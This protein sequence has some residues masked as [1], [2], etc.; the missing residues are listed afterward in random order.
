MKLISEGRI[1]IRIT[2]H[3]YRYMILTNG[4]RICSAMTSPMQKESIRE[5]FLPGYFHIFIIL[6]VGVLI[7]RL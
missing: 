5:Y 2:G 6:R 4:R 3:L 1:V 7:I